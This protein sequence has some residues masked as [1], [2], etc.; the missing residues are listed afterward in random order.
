VGGKGESR[1]LV[2]LGEAGMKGRRE[3]KGSVEVVLKYLNHCL[4]VQESGHY[5][6][7]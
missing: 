7:T 3:H 4:R 2:E 5:N 6:Q 1:I